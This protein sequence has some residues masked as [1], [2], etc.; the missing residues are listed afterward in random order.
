M[1][2][3]H[4]AYHHPMTLPAQYHGH[5]CQIRNTRGNTGAIIIRPGTTV[6][7]PG[8]THTLDVDDR[9]TVEGEGRAD[10]YTV[11]IV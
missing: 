2:E 6:V 10:S 8:E 1:R 5:R 11:R 3:A 7:W 4:P 9:V